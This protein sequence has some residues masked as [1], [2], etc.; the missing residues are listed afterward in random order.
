MEEEHRSVE[1]RTAVSG[2]VIAQRIVYYVGGVIIAILFVRLLLQLLGANPGADFVGFVYALSATFV[3]PFFGIF[4]QP[5]FG[6]SQFETSTLV[7]IVVYTLV[8]VGVARLIS[9]AQP[10][11]EV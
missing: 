7:A 2:I 11:Q 8:M 3:A 1:K 10:Q 5:T 4:G 6:Q 9:L